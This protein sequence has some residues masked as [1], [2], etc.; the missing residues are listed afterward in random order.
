MLVQ[1]LPPVQHLA[2]AKTAITTKS[3][4]V[5]ARLVLGLLIGTSYGVYSQPQS[6]AQTQGFQI[7]PL[8]L[9]LEHY[10]PDADRGG[11]LLKQELIATRERFWGGDGEDPAR[12]LRLSP[13]S[14]SASRA[15]FDGRSDDLGR[16]RFV[17]NLLRRS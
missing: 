4:D 8:D 5:A 1:R 10:G 11:E 2:D 17:R 12:S 7:L 3:D 9:T 13:R 16:P 14:R 6:E 15:A